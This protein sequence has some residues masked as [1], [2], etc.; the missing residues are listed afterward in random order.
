MLRKLIKPILFFP[1]C[2]Y[3]TA[4][5]SI[6]SET[7]TFIDQ[8]LEE[9]E[10]KFFVDYS[11]IN[12]IIIQNNPELKSLKQLVS[13]A[14]FN[15]SSQISK[16]YP[17]IDL[18]STGL[19]KYTVG[20]NYSSNSFTTSTSQF[21]TNP[22]LTIKWDLIDPLRGSEIQIAKE[23]YKI[24]KNNFEITKRDLTQEAKARYHK[25]QKSLQDIKNSKFALDL[26]NTTLKDAQAKFDA[27]IG[28][29][30]E[31]L[32]AD[33][34]VSR[35]K[36][37]LN[38]KKI[39]NE[40]N[41]ISLKEILNIKDNFEINQQQ[42]LIGFW[43]YKLNKN[44]RDSFSKNLSLKN[45]SLKKSI[46]ENQAK[47]FVNASK[48]NIYI[49]NTFSSSFSNADSSSVT[50]DTS[51]S[52]SSYSNSIS[53]NLAWNFFSGGQNKNSY[54]SKK[55]E[56]QAEEYSL[57]NFKNTLKTNIMTTYLNL[58]LNE[59]KILTSLKEINST[60]ESLRLSKLRY[61]VGI[62]TLKDVLVRQKE[63]SIAK[64]KNIEAIYNYNLN[65]DELERLTFLKASNNCLSK[66]SK[67]IN[68]KKSI[69]NLLI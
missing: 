48:P 50:L 64:S 24:A 14:T 61:E 36:Q 13:A 23:N 10:D 16:R 45:I 60:K 11:E 29:K 8:V 25:Y 49:S 1:L 42:K 7:G 47:N 12:E 54:K 32:E 52:S 43:H 63:L 27:G 66:E 62:S 35:D 26:S 51:E 46:K 34:Q 2:L 68:D 5:K 4:P 22:S 31:V 39:Q 41:K 9:K 20:K 65:I 67:R 3:L 17:S 59:E 28:T 18:K 55:L 40:I 44:I 57:N 69:C 38:E 21:S 37:A 56:A 53:I 6:L 58:K 15:I 30:F 19:P 33:A